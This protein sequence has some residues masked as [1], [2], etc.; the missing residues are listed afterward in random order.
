MSQMLLKDVLTPTE[1]SRA[2]YGMAVALAGAAMAATLA[3]T[4]C[5]STGQTGKTAA[6]TSAHS[7][8]A[9]APAAAAPTNPAPGR[10]DK[11]ALQILNQIIQGEFAAVRAD[12]DSVMKQRLSC[13][14]LSSAW[15]AYQQTFGSYQ[16]HGDPQ[17]VSRGDLTVVNVPLHMALM[18]GELRVTFHGDGSIAGLYL[19]RAGIPVP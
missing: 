4:G 2:P 14:E 1:S 7:P 3:L 19:L 9:S 8:G 5:D 6:S 16:S 15:A 10:D 11:R 12:F 17:D 18:P 13:Q